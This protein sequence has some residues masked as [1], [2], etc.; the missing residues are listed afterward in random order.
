M[1]VGGKGKDWVHPSV[2]PDGPERDA[3]IEAE[4]DYASKH[5]PKPPIL[6]ATEQWTAYDWRKYGP[7]KMDE[8]PKKTLWQRVQDL[9]AKM[10]Q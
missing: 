2:L 5:D 1:I 10:M 3:W 4:A 9:C 6:T 8:E 7:R